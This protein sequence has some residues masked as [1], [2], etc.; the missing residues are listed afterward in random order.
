VELTEFQ[1]NQIGKNNVEQ[2][3]RYR[4]IFMTANKLC[5][6]KNMRAVNAIAPNTASITQHI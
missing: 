1:C 3:K 5:K 6:D 4:V 2:G